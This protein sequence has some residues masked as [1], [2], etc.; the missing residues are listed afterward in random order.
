LSH[1]ISSMLTRPERSL[2][3]F[4]VKDSNENNSIKVSVALAEGES[5]TN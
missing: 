3:T 1:N 5:S 2:Q 4:V